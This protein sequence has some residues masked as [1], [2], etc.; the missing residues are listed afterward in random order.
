MLFVGRY[1]WA[2]M[3]GDQGLVREVLREELGLRV[4]DEEGLSEWER[5]NVELQKDRWGGYMMVLDAEGYSPSFL[6]SFIRDCPAAGNR[7]ARED[8]ELLFGKEGDGNF[9]AFLS[10]PGTEYEF[11]MPGSLV[12][13]GSS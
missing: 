5:E 1:D 6:A 11:G 3:S 7:A 13:L 9:G 4:R 8:T 12:C 10:V 2:W